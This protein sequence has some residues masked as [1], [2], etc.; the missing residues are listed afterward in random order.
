MANMIKSLVKAAISSAGYTYGKTAHL[1]YGLDM[2]ND[3][4]RLSQHWGFSVECIFDVGANVGQSSL[5][6][7]QAFPKAHVVAFEPTPQ[8]FERLCVNTEH[9]TRI[10]PE[11]IAI[12]A[13]PGYAE[14]NLYDLAVLNSLTSRTAYAARYNTSGQQVTCKIDTIDDYCARNAISRVD[15]LKV[16]TE[17]S[18]LPVLC[19]AREMLSSGRIRFVYCEFNELLPIP[20][21]EG[22]AL[23]PLAEF[24]T[25]LGF[26]FLA[27]YC[28]R[29][30]VEGAHFLVSN[31]L[32]VK[33]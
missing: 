24:L 8:S 22:G 2:I 23:V 3:V 11:P 26:K 28:D 1:P 5:R 33:R 31:A 15:L 30:E 21:V 32:F 7:V 29:I 25:P 13:E 4:G 10:K 17:G 19:G 18:E 14:L 20:G 12:G 9:L 16:D 6:Y 27:T